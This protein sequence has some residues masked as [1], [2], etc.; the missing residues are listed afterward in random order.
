MYWESE[1]PTFTYAKGKGADIEATALATYAL[2]KYNRYI[3][4]VNKAISYLIRSKYPGGNWGTTQ[5]TVLSLKCLLASLKGSTENVNATVKVFLNGKSKE[6]I[7]LD[8]DNADIMFL[9]DLAQATVEGKNEITISIDGKGNP[10]YE[11]AS[12][13]Y[14]PWTLVETEKRKDILSIDVDYDKTTLSQD[15]VITCFVKVTNNIT[16]SADMVI[17]DLGIPP[18]FS[19]DT[20]D[21]QKLVG[22]KVEKYNVT[23]R[24]IILYIERIN[25]KKPIEFSYRLKAKFP[26]NAKTTTSKVYKYYEP[27]V[28]TVAEP[29]DIEVKG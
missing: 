22:T 29:V 15:D 24:Q 8:K 1:I 16:A 28:E 18:G 9:I 5:A 25:Y 3:T 17:V 27:E 4:I 14:I 20:G 11:I 12:R 6:T 2:L 19:V 13:Y 23:A 7:H 26:I 21:L 10:M